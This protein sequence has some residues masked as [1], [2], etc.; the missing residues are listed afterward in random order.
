MNLKPDI[1]RRVARTIKHSGHLGWLFHRSRD[2]SIYWM[3]SEQDI[4]PRYTSFEDIAWKFE[5]AGFSA[6]YVR[7]DARPVSEDWK[8]LAY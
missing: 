6:C 2:N 4:N 1:A 8:F 3:A 5:E 7:A